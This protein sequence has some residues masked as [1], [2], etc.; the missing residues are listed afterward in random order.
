MSKVAQAQN[1]S[2]TFSK[3]IELILSRLDKVKQA[4]NG[5]MARCP[6]HADKNPSLSITEGDDG[7]VLLKCFAGCTTEDIVKALG[8]TMADLF[9][10]KEK[11][12][13]HRKKTSQ[14]PTYVYVNE[15]GKPLFGII[16]TPEKQFMAVRP[17]KNGGWIYGMGKVTPT[18]YNLPRVVEAASKGELVFVVEG[19]KDADNLTKVGLTATTNPFGAE[20]W[21]PEYADYLISADVVI[22]PDND[23]VGR[24]HALQVAQ[25]LIGKA[26]RIRVLELPNLPPKG[27]VSDWLEAGGT[28]E[29]LLSMAEQ[30]PDY[31]PKEALPEKEPQEEQTKTGKITQ[32]Q[33]LVELVGIHEIGLFHTPD[34]D[35]WA[36]ID[37][38]GHKEHWPIKSKSFRR[39]LSQKFY[40]LEGKPPTAQAMQDALNVIEAQAQFEGPEENVYVRLSERGNAAIYLDLCNDNWEVVKITKKGWQVIKNPKI[41]FC[42]AKG[43]LAL[44]YPERGGSIEELRK[45]VNVADEQSWQLLIAFILACL[46]PKGPYPVL[47]LYGA[48]GSAK[49]TTARV[50][51]ELIDPAETI[52]R[53]TPKDERDLAIAAKNSWILGFDNVSNIPDWLSDAICRL[54][55]GA[56]FTTRK[57]YSDSEEEIFNFKRPCTLNGITEFGSRHDLIDRALILTLPEIPEKKRKQEKLFWAE[58]EEAKGRILGAFLDAVVVGLQRRGRIELEGLPRMADFA[59]WIV[60]CEPALPWAEGEFMANYVENRREA[61]ETAIANDPVCEAVKEFIRIEKSWQGTATELLEELEYIVGKTKV[62]E[63]VIK[64]R[65]WPQNGRALSAR[66]KRSIDFLRAVGVDIT[67]GRADGRKVIRIMDDRVAK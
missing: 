64:S 9:P 12:A 3:P 11:P 60:S 17:D 40:D 54:S 63:R 22:I 52:L 2:N 66:L 34:M 49:S 47:L 18:L 4:G 57:L 50:I 5:Y 37:I 13:Q 16:R 38:E 44:P 25:S 62:G 23:K 59:H 36:T 27:D 7:R 26:K 10:H 30:A 67:H 46:E 32:S 39:Y 15:E 48:Q 41:K 61:I 24:R 8:L 6:A 65:A 29:N 20:K 45:F 51:K 56:G 28:K 31:E 1:E 19:E 55:T 21:K 53:S 33:K 14:K 35:C 58:F 43:A 42:R